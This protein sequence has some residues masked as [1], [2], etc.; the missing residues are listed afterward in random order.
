MVSQHE[1]CLDSSIDHCRK[2]F[3]L[4]PTHKAFIMNKSS[5]LVLILG[6]GVF[7]VLFAFMIFIGLC[8]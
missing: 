3:C 5:D 8:I 7:G 1:R 6:G 2:R 4:M